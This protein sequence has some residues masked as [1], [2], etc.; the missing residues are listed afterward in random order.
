M[1][2]HLLWECG[3]WPLHLGLVR[4]LSLPVLKVCSKAESRQPT[5]THPSP[6]SKKPP[7]RRVHISLQEKEER[8]WR[9]ETARTGSVDVQCQCNTVWYNDTSLA[10]STQDGVLPQS[11][12]LAWAKQTNR[13]LQFIYVTVSV[14]NQLSWCLP[15][16]HGSW[17]PAWYYRTEVGSR[18]NSAVTCHS[19]LPVLVHYNN[20]WPLH[21]TP[22]CYHPSSRL[23]TY[24]N[25]RI[26]R[27]WTHRW[28]WSQTGK[29]TRPALSALA[30]PWWGQWYSAH[31][32]LLPEQSHEID[33]R[34]W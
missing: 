8:C 16:L 24:P 21:A 27:F 23:R 33:I 30:I 19:T 1:I 28:S 18:Y 15:S 11:N 32:W 7:V 2:V 10:H 5:I 4:P 31:H 22:P 29:A 3:V 25:S 14:K 17:M 12:N 26:F 13:I 20:L 6:G 34:P 9:V